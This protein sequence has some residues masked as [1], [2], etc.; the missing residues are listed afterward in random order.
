LSN[1][2]F[3]LFQLQ[4]IDRRL[5]QIT[6]RLS[7]IDSQLKNDQVLA[8]VRKVYDSSVLVLKKLMDQLDSV[9]KKSTEKRVKIEISESSLYGGSVKNPKELS[10]LQQEIASLKSFL[11][12]LENEQIELMVGSEEQQSVVDKNKSALDQATLKNEVD[13]QHLYAEKKDLM[14]EINRISIEKSAMNQQ[15]NPESL[16]LYESLRKSKKGIAVAKIEDQC[17]TIC[18]SQLPPAECQMAKSSTQIT[19]CSSCG[20]I[21]YAD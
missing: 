16:V 12:N 2:S 18:G 3:Y 21:L 17:C 15:I 20:R 9:E 8:D 19:L 1:Q 11:Q 10:G 4:K 14:N 5:D 13:N 7:Q 6:S